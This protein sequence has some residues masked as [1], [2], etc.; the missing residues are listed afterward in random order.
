MGKKKEF[1][2]TSNQKSTVSRIFLGL[3]LLAGAGQCRAQVNP[4][5]GD[6]YSPAPGRLNSAAIP[7]SLTSDPATSAGPSASV[8]APAGTTAADDGWH[9]AVSPYLWFPGVHGTIGA[10]GRDVSFKAS[11]GDLL[12]HF[13]FGL[14]G[15][16]EAIS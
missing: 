4:T 12:S 2:L 8:S 16:L 5:L 7:V 15:L 3:F 10:L 1:L 6:A 11:P 9:F 13:R 14:M